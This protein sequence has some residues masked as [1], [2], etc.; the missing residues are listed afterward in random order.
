MGCNAAPDRSHDDLGALAALWGT[1]TLQHAIVAAEA[2]NRVVR[3]A[4]LEHDKALREIG[5]ARTYR[6][7]IF[8][9]SAL[10]SQSLAHLGLTFPMGSFGVYPG[11]GPV[12]G[13]TTTLT[14]PLQP[15]GIFYASV[16]QP[17]SQ[18]RKIGLSIELAR[19]GAAIADETVRWRRQA[20]VNEVRR[21]YYGILQT[22]ERPA[23]FAGDRRIS[24]AAR[25]GYGPQRL[26]ACCAASG[27]T[28][29]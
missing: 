9:V 10:G 6:L 16:A 28:R 2:N 14:G 24:E 12:P 15:A 21:L 19:V 23:E 8:S 13:K 4:R 5:V 20:T 1:L 25:S 17:L 22:E 29:R 11:I 7:P 18:Q 3:A 27:L 26:A